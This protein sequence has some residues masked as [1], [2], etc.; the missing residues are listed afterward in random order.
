MAIIQW[1]KSLSVNVEEIDRQHQKLIVM[2]NDLGDAMRQGKGKEV[3]GRI[4]Q[5]M[6][7]YTIT[8]FSYEE[9]YFDRFGYPDATTHKKAHADF[10]K[11]VSDVKTKFDS[12]QQGL[13]IEILNFLSDWL[14]THIKGTDKK[15]GP[16]FN[17][18]GLK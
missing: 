6:V 3:L 10:V 5:G 15:Y 1:D 18:K 8:H 9:K 12:G 13:P 11:K 14:G 2:I 17:E 7:S 4:I 16:F